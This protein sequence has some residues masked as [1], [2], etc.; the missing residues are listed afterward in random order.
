MFNIYYIF[1]PPPHIRCVWLFGSL[2]PQ[3][4]ANITYISKLPK[5]PSWYFTDF[6]PPNYDK[7]HIKTWPSFISNLWYLTWRS[8]HPTQS[9]YFWVDLQG[10][11]S[12]LNFFL[13]AN[14]V[15]SRVLESCSGSELSVLF[16]IA[17]ALHVGRSPQI[18]TVCN[19]VTWKNQK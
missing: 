9:V 8:I 5:N 10:C 19:S 14:E 3:G 11:T 6:F 12:A 16:S 18:C 13:R 15:I 7:K 1:L 2:S 4:A 17:L